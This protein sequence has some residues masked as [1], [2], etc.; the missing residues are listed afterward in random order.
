VTEP[1]E[2]HIPRTLE[3][4]DP[5]TYL[6]RTGVAQTLKVCG[7]TISSETLATKVSR[8]GGPP[9]RKFGRTPMYLWGDVVAWVKSE[10][11]G[12]NERQ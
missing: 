10:I 4:I 2:T 6:T 5:Q 1:H 8:G 9:F 3:S 7:I 11:G 12:Q